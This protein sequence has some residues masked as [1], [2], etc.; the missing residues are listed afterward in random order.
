MLSNEIR[1]KFIAFFEKR[2]HKIIPSTSLVPDKDFFESSDK[3]ELLFVNSGMQPLSPYLMGKAHPEGKRLVNIQKCVRTQ[4]ID[5]VGDNT[6][7]TFFEMMGNWSLGDYFKEDAIKWSYEFLTSKEEGLGLDKDRLYIT[8]FAGNES[9]PKDI[10]SAEL[11]EKAGIPKERIYFLESN[12]WSPGENGPCGPDTEMFYD[13]TSDGL[14]NLT[15]EEY[16]QADQKQQVVEIW[17]DVFMEYERKD[18]K[19]IGKLKQKNVD[20]GSGLE[21]VA[22][23]VQGKDNIFDTDLFKE[24]YQLLINLPL[25]EKAKRIILDHMRTS[26]FLIADGV[27]PSNKDRGYILRRLMR[28]AARYT[29]QLGET[30]QVLTFLASFFAEKYKNIYSN[31]L[32]SDQI[33]KEEV[34]KE[35]QKFR[36]TLERGLKEFEKGVD[37]FILATTYGF[38]IELTEELAKEKG[39]HIDREEFDRK[40]YEHQKL[41]QT[42][43]AG[44]FKGGLANHNEKT[45]KLHTAHHL[46]L[47]ALQEVVNPDIK[48]KGSNITEERLRMDFLCDHKLTD[49]EKNKIEDWVNDRISEGLNV[50]RKEM[51][52][53]EAEKIGAQMEFGAK[54]PDIVSVYFIEDKNG[55]AVSKEFCGGPH[56]SNTKELGHFKIQKEEAVAQGVRRIKGILE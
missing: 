23:A 31:L 56:V 15:L 9:A 39:I 18:G 53:T 8:C 36:K 26:V 21:R 24:A 13:I 10:E 29:S 6:H 34:L 11:W 35:E 2:G 14:G 25:D 28:R 32:T 40:M 51:P 19:V 54:Y 3:H 47:A 7:D 16:L 30:S 38:P 43:S 17:N 55:N 42:S 45:V 20:T 12:W 37:P 27:K 5:E 52:L 1:D 44:M 33:I 46:L 41:S 22:M 50:I 49:E 48:Q 4:D